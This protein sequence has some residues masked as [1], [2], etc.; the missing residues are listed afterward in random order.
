MSVEELLL[1][2]MRAVA[3]R[4]KSPRSRDEMGEASNSKSETQEVWATWVSSARRSSRDCDTTAASKG[5][6]T[7]LSFTERRSLREV[8]LDCLSERS[9]STALDRMQGGV[10]MLQ[11][12]TREV[13]Q[14]RTGRE[15]RES[16][17]VSKMRALCEAVLWA[18]DCVVHSVEEIEFECFMSVTKTATAALKV[19]AGFHAALYSAI[20]ELPTASGDDVRKAFP[21]LLMDYLND[22]FYEEIQSARPGR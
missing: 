15:V 21:Q 6:I 1:V 8:R 17:K 2:D 19:P 13:V 11:Q 16:T 22:A 18:V 12:R 4:S 14:L 10:E 20:F 9:S 7:F 3:S 5:P